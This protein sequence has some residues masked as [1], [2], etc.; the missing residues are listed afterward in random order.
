MMLILPPEDW[1]D[2]EGNKLS[3]AGSQRNPGVLESHGTH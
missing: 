2:T 1:R 3:F